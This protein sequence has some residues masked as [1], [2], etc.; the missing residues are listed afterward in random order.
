MTGFASW[1]FGY[2]PL[3]TAAGDDDGGPCDVV[4]ATNGKVSRA[5]LV[6]ALVPL[7]PDAQVEII[8]AVPP[9]FWARVTASGCV[10]RAQI[11]AAL[12]R[13]GVPLRYVASARR[14]STS[15][16]PPLDFA[17]AKKA[18]PRDWRARKLARPPVE[19]PYEAGMWFLGAEELG[20][21]VDR[22]TCGYGR[23]TRLAVI[24][25]DAA[26][27]EAIGF[28]AVLPIGTAK[29][30]QATA[31]G[32][33]L[34]AWATG[35]GFDPTGGTLA[36]HGVAPGASPRLYCIPKPGEDVS[37]LPLAIATAVT[38]GA[39]VIVAATY[40]EGSQSPMLDDA[41]AFAAHVGRRGRGTAVVLP[42]GRETSSPPSSVHASLA[43]GYAEPA[44]HPGVFCVAPG[45]RG[46]GWFLYRDRRG[47][48]RPFANRGPQVRWLA[49]GDDMAYPLGTA[50]SHA[51]PTTTRQRMCHA[52]SSGAS[53]IAAGVL[54]LV[55]ANNPALDVDELDALV[56]RTAERPPPG[57]EA[58]R[59]PLADP[60]DVLPIA[61]DR[62]GHDAKHGF[63]HL[64][65]SRACASARDPLAMAFTAIGADAGAVASLAFGRRFYSGALAR[66][67][68]R[69]LLHDPR[70]D[71]ALR[72]IARHVRLV[73]EGP[74]RRRA[75][76]DAALARHLA[77][78][79]RRLSAATA[80]RG[81]NAPPARVREELLALARD[82]ARFT[83]TGAI[84]EGV[85]KATADA[86]ELLAGGA[87]GATSRAGARI[88]TVTKTPTARAGARHEDSRSGLGP[89]D[90]P[91]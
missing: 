70:A 61:A 72:S 67:A 65:A 31:H 60:H 76:G 30:P 28:D 78:F 35:S 6:A 7:L 89:R 26:D 37:S 80:S 48:L 73:G 82:A 81:V 83:A 14:G 17:D 25:D 11:A 50:A 86:L 59:A 79:L 38:H 27:A 88:P 75:H 58:G 39:D 84:D 47:F 34:A 62:D 68:V 2:E 1:D 21:A 8:F 10:R 85:A 77:L 49:P 32:A 23:G 29:M 4:V 20:V 55:L 43:L 18:R 45:A 53:A 42:T 3:P 40:V 19:P 41:L 54:L 5:E 51:G 57:W 87:H 33:L 74:E 9:V 46:G 13:R 63:G 69:A 44:S 91:A 52:E 15:L 12:A 22:A 56:T 71:L 90:V 24:D 64:H 16:A 36:F 66:W